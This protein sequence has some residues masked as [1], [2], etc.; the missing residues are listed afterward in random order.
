MIYRHIGGGLFAHV[1]MRP[2]LASIVPKNIQQVMLANSL[3]NKD[4][5]FV[6][7]I[8]SAGSGKTLL[9]ISA[10]I[11]QVL[12]KHDY[13]KIIIT[14]PIMPIGKDLGYLPG[15]VNE[16]MAQWVRPF[17]NNI[18]YI[19]N[20]NSSRGKNKV[21]L[22]KV[23]SLL[24]PEQCKDYFQILP[25]TYMRG[26]SINNAFII[27]DEAQNSTPSQMK[28]IITRVG[29]GSKLVLTGDI[30]QIDN[31]FLSRECNGLTMA[32]KKFWNHDLYSHITLKSV[33]RSKLAELATEI[34]F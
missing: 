8:G 5:P 21:S 13:R 28:T 31:R 11:Q 14:R 20:V 4:I 33:Q 12:I 32:I 22:T 17:M 30:N 34:L 16:K 19:M 1:D 15:D 29:Q 27:V 18:E 3:V 25:I 7:M 23:G 24:K 9:A 10:A 2:H 6:S 26:S